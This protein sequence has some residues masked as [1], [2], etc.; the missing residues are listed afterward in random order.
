MSNAIVQEKKETKM[1][2]FNTICKSMVLALCFLFAVTFLVGCN[3]S[4]GDNVK[5][6]ITLTVNDKTMGS[7]YGSGSYG[8]NEHITIYASPKEGYKFVEWSDG[9]KDSVRTIIVNTDK[10]LSAI[11]AAEEEQYYLNSVS[12]YCAPIIANVSAGYDEIYLFQLDIRYG[13]KHLGGFNQDVSYL[14]YDR[15]ICIDGYNKND[16]LTIYTD[17][18][19]QIL[20]NKNQSVELYTSPVFQVLKSNTAVDKT[21]TN[22][23]TVTVSEGA[24]TP[25]IICT[26]SA[27]VGNFNVYITFN[28]QKA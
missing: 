11:F 24:S 1:K 15:A 20:F 17:A 25:Q 18:S 8:V 28:F 6:S 9:N 4:G 22:K 19:Q 26:S 23:Q 5:S 7:V 12:L 3:L 14:A 21:I 27:D 10:E 2:K 16:K 13:S